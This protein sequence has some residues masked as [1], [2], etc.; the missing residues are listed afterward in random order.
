MT[1]P[2]QRVC[3]QVQALG[4]HVDEEAWRKALNAIRNWNPSSPTASMNSASRL[5]QAAGSA[6]NWPSLTASTLAE[7]GTSEFDPSICRRLYA[8]L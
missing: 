4:Q 5:N 7:A 6:R 3:L 8:T 1:R 2:R